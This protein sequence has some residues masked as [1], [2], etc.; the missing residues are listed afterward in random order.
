MNLG[1]VD[2]YEWSCVVADDPGD[3]VRHARVL[4]PEDYRGVVEARIVR[5]M[6]AAK[7]EQGMR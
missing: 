3:V 4:T 6:V 7:T 5:L 2:R 1:H